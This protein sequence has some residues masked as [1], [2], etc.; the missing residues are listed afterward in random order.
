MTAGFLAS[1]SPTSVRD[2][3]R[4]ADL[5]A[6]GVDPTMTRAVLRKRWAN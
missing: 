1:A 4:F 2:A 3:Y 5:A 6:D